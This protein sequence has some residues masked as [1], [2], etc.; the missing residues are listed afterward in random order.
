MNYDG[1]ETE[2]LRIRIAAAYLSVFWRET[3]KTL[4]NNMIAIEVLNQLYYSIFQGPN[5]GLDLG[6]D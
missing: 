5:N 2:V 3:V 1:S 6:L 4:L